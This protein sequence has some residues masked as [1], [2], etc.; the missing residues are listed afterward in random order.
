MPTNNM[1]SYH[2]SLKVLTYK[3]NLNLI[4]MYAPVPQ[5][6]VLGEE[7]EYVPPFCPW[8]TQAGVELKP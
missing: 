3:K 7:N 4:W 5:K 6:S 8:W 1:N 2:V